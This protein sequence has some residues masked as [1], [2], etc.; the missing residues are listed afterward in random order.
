MSRM[1]TTTKRA[2]KIT[3]SLALCLPIAGCVF[4]H[5]ARESWFEVRGKVLVNNLEASSDCVLELYRRKGDEKVRE[6]N[7][8]PEFQRSFVIA[9]GIHEYYMLLHCP[10]SSTYKTQTYKLGST[11]YIAHP[12]DLGEIHL[13]RSDH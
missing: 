5:P 11:Y 8:S 7:V 2:S 9:P 12:V 6:I 3:L 13:T 10:G 1:Q 4:F